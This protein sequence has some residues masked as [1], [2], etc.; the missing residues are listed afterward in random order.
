MFKKGT[1]KRPS[2]GDLSGDF[3]NVITDPS[4]RI[5]GFIGF[6]LDLPW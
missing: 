5:P 4:K 2:I 6:F 1:F 3:D